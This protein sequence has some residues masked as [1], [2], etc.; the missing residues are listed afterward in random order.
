MR[1]NENLPRVD[2]LLPCCG[3]PVEVILDTVRA[4]CT[5]DYPVSSFR[6][7]VLDDGE[8]SELHRAV[9]GLRSKWPHLFY[10]S[11]GKQSGRVFA[12]AG[13][14]NYALF[15]VQGKGKVQPDYC[16]ILDADSIPQPE[17]LRATLPHLLQNPQ[18]SLVTTR[19]Y[20][21]NLPAGDPLSQSRLHFYACQNAE[22][23]LRGCAIDAGSGAVFRRKTIVDDAGGYPTFSFSEDWQLSLILHGLGHRCVQVQEPLQFGLVPASLEGH[24]AQRNRWYIGHSQQ[25]FALRPPTSKTL[26]RHIQ[27]SIARGGFFMVLALVGNMLG[28]AAVPLLLTSGQLIPATSPL[29]V[30]VQVILALLQ[31]A[32]MWIYGWLQNAHAGIRGSP[33][34][35]LENS[36]MAPCKMLASKSYFNE[37]LLAN[38]FMSEFSSAP[39]RH[40]PIPFL[41]K[42]TQRILRYR[43]HGQFMEPPHHPP[44]LQKA[45][46]EPA[47]GQCR[48]ERPPPHRYRR[49]YALRIDFSPS[50]QS[51]K[52][53]PSHTPPDFPGLATITPS[54]LPDS[55]EPLGTCGVYTKPT[56]LSPA[57][58][59]VCAGSYGW[60]QIIVSAGEKFGVVYSS[61]PCSS[62]YYLPFLAV[63]HAGFR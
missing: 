52:R 36:W 48:T 12:K 27:W 61:R 43:Q 26:P 30:K 51:Q 16:A 40:H 41:L 11:R 1:G 35:H 34:V 21:D 13:N 54:M 39:I 31:I 46:P 47:T 2:I 14:L 59:S 42:Q 18:A 50:R 23:D 37:E 9:N 63:G 62:P 8:S 57:G 5:L 7:L 29:L 3:E 32:M 20:F 28:Y 24:I 55:D 44:F 15:D 58:V 45:L 22:L 56:S 38:S 53:N 17:F 25:V 60:R 10:H 19:Q 4:A 33:F 49:S 6:V